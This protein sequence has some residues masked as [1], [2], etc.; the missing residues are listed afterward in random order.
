MKR[1]HVET[2]GDQLIPA[3]SGLNV[4][5][6]LLRLTEPGENL[7]LLLYSESNAA[8]FRIVLDSRIYPFIEPFWRPS[9]LNDWV[10]NARE[11]ICLA[12]YDD[13]NTYYTILITLPWKWETSLEVLVRNP[14]IG[15][16]H[17]IVTLYYDR[18]AELPLPEPQ[19]DVQTPAPKPDPEM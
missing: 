14:T 9:D 13:A 16:T 10:P 4:W 15:D 6:P 11:G 8:Q 18:L 3:G 17:A 2:S 7:L 1:S 5:N 19:Q 12:V